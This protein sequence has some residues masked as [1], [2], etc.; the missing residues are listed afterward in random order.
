MKH[1]K[2]VMKMVMKHPCFF[3]V[4]RGVFFEKN[5]GR[6]DIYHQQVDYGRWTD[7]ETWLV[8]LVFENETCV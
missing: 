6:P 7:K 1:P 5:L 4:K 2:M 3:P 8:G